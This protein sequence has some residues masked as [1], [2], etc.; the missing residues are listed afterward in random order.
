MARFVAAA[1]ALLLFLLFAATPSTPAAAA[2]ANAAFP[3]AWTHNKTEWRSRLYN[4]LRL[5]PWQ[6]RLLEGALDA[7]D[8]VKAPLTFAADAAA[9]A[10][11]NA[12][13]AAKRQHANSTIQQL[14]AAP[15]E[16]AANETIS[17]VDKARVSALNKTEIALR[18]GVASL[19][20]PASPSRFLHPLAASPPALLLADK[21]NVSANAVA[22]R[23]ATLTTIEQYRAAAAA[24]KAGASGLPPPLPAITFGS[25]PEQIGTSTA[26]ATKVPQ[27]AAARRAGEGGENAQ[28]LPDWTPM[29]PGSGKGASASSPPPLPVPP[30]PRDHPSWLVHGGDDGEIAEWVAAAPG[31]F[32]GAGSGAGATAVTGTRA[33]DGARALRLAEWIEGAPRPLLEDLESGAAEGDEGGE[34]VTIG[35]DDVIRAP[36]LR[37]TV[38]QR[39]PTPQEVTDDARVEAVA[40][41]AAA[42]AAAA[43]APA[44]AAAEA[45]AAESAADGSSL[46]A[47][48]VKAAAAAASSSSPRTSPQSS[49]ATFKSFLREQDFN[50]SN[51]RTTPGGTFGEPVRFWI[52]LRFCFF[53][54][55]AT[56][57]KF[58]LFLIYFLS[59]KKIKTKGTGAG[60]PDLPGLAALG[61]RPAGAALDPALLHLPGSASDRRPE[62]ARRG[63]GGRKRGTRLRRR[64]VVRALFRK[65]QARGQLQAG[66]SG[67]DGDA[68]HRSCRGRGVRSGPSSGLGGREEKDDDEEESLD[69]GGGG[70]GDDGGRGERCRC[71]D[72]D[73]AFSL[74]ACRVSSSSSSSSSSFLC[75]RICCS[76]GDGL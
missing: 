48:V 59:S 44:A 22:K 50:G 34:F 12:T 2:T 27:L 19:S 72:S 36:A 65:D 33:D 17:K 4:S 6:V 40:A 70:D 58:S 71:R 64:R 11:A 15:L 24:A 38:E 39:V 5:T 47:A 61:D 74:R 46:E 67:T 7:R 66:V 73:P 10:V 9:L 68:L 56:K 51:F 16:R 29:G 31:G 18:A 30:L 53:P 52:S 21:L 20:S 3:P 23:I 8:A 49:P 28:E 60:D 55:S 69:G 63:L 14:V 76:R 42:A 37:A 43:A 62:G 13:F 1:V 41:G 35:P 25:A 54:L 45:A 32:V 57:T 26:A 75:S